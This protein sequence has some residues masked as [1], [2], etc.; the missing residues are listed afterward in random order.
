MPVSH[1][2]P[3]YDHDFGNPYHDMG[4]DGMTQI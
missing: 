4:W 1:F 3:F 2:K